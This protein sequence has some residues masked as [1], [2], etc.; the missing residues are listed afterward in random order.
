MNV[1]CP[2]CGTPI[3]PTWDFCQ[4]CG[5]DPDGLRPSTWRKPRPDE[6]AAPSLPVRA[7]GCALK[8]TGL[9]IIG[10]IV[11]VVLLTGA[12]V[13][14]VKHNATDAGTAAPAPTSEPTTTTTTA[15]VGRMP[16]SPPDG[17]FSVELP[18]KPIVKAVPKHDLFGGGPGF[19]YDADNATE[20]AIIGFDVQPDRY[21]ADPAGY[22]DAVIDEYLQWSGGTI[23]LKTPTDVGGL[24]ASKFVVTEASGFTDQATL[25]VAGPKAYILLVSTPPGVPADADTYNH[26]LGSFHPAS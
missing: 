3:L 21:A 19:Q 13:V 17:S 1:T 22:L 6:L 9:L 18:G 25:I 8:A 15:P 14:L 4:H 24:P 16:F 11:V 23:G 5:Y 12:L 20:F 10:T 26:Y 2:E 7:A